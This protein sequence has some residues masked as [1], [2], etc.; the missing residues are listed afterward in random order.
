MDGGGLV[1]NENGNLETVWK[2]RNKIYACERG[3]PQKEIGEGRGCTMES[4]NGKNVYA[5]TED[6]EV[7][8]LLPQGIKK[9]LG[10]GS[11]PIIKS[12]NNQHVICVWENEKQIHSAAVEL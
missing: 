1:I 6:G 2:R 9:K 11:L 5:W 8:I 7:V 10:A 3:K 4:M 12:I